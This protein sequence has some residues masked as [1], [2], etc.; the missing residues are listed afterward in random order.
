MTK[1][2]LFCTALACLVFIVG[3]PCSFAA[4]QA[5]TIEIYTTQ[6]LITLADNCKLDSWS[7][8]KTVLLMNDLDIA[9]Q[10]FV[11]IPTFGGTFDG[12]KHMI[13]GFSY[14]DTNSRAGFFDELQAGAVIKDITLKG[15]ITPAGSQTHIGGFVGINHGTVQNCVFTG[16]VTGT[17]YVGGVAG[18]NDG[19]ITNC[20]AYGYIAATH[21]TGGIVGYNSGTLQDCVNNAQINTSHTEVNVTEQSLTQIDWLN[22]RSA[23]NVPSHTDTGGVAGYSD[24][25]ILSCTNNGAVGYPHV[26]YNVGGIVGRQAGYMDSCTNNTLIHG[27][28]DVGGIVGQMV[29]YI[30]LQYTGTSIAKLQS[31]INTLSDMVDK[32]AT[33]AQSASSAA[34]VR[35]SAASGYLD[36]AKS[37]LTD[38]YNDPHG[39]NTAAEDRITASVTGL[40]NEMQG[41]TGELS[42]SGASLSA[43]IRAAN[44]QMNSVMTLFLGMIDDVYT[45]THAQPDSFYQ[46]VS[47]KQMSQ[48][49]DGKIENCANKGVVD[50]DLNVGGIAGTMA[51]EYDVDPEEDIAVSGGRSYR[52]QYQTKA[53][54]LNCTNS[55]AVTAKK[56]CVGGI[57]GK[58][59]LGIV[60]NG[61]I[62]GAVSTTNG[63]KAGGIA[64]ESASTLRGCF[65]KCLVT[66]ETYIGGIAG[67]AEDI[68]SCYA[69]V[70]L[71]S[72]TQAFGAIAGQATGELTKN[73]FVSDTLTGVD[74]INYQEKAQPIT[75]QDLLA[76]EA[77]PPQFKTFNL[78][79][80]ADDATLQTISFPYG[81]SVD[82]SQI[83]PIPQ[84]AGYYA[85][86]SKTNYTDLTFDETVQ[87]VYV[88][89]V[90]PL[91]SKQL[92]QNGQSVLLVQGNFTHLDSLILQAQDAALY[93]LDSRKAA[94]AWTLTVPNDGASSHV[95]RYIPPKDLNK[96]DLYVSTNQGL[97]LLALQPQGSYYGF[98]AAGSSLTLVVFPHSYGYTPWLIAA[99]AFVLIILIVA[100]LFIK[101]KNRKKAGTSK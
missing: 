30:K 83:P 68:A 2:K 34:S 43:D 12:Q 13:N 59:D 9:G 38:I 55:G 73:Y 79:F 6:D 66:G 46:D 91:A 82:T 84:K 29:P 36:T 45:T 64:G 74:R 78:T 10:D 49:T 58:M 33:D 98:E 42:A 90:T 37:G 8:G 71:E 47:D 88:P 65:A 75:Y 50:G 1:R 25:K 101:K 52:Y 81:E 72:C 69:L 51:I 85:H 28:K 23:Q 67:T 86:W 89:F 22:L 44:T 39:D 53:I 15:N 97:Q 11:S 31:E 14:S 61:Q 24:G 77:L 57:V 19:T 3:A 94:E 80:C 4:D 99:G 96:F 76:V 20:A 41:L 95:F 62:Y 18:L 63:G 48:I 87:A 92:R 7:V 56:D 17:D 54:T 32:T 35:L 60:V 16:S 93:H 100:L 27:R 40:S 26:G 21:F 70:K 5:A